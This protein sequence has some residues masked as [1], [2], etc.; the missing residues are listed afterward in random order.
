V[1]AHAEAVTQLVRLAVDDDGAGHR[2]VLLPR[3]VGRVEDEADAPVGRP[4]PA[5][6]KLY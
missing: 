3:V 4:V 2:H 5:S 6:K 1:V